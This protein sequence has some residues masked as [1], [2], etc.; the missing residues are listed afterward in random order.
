MCADN[1]KMKIGIKKTRPTNAW[2]VS[3]HVRHILQTFPSIHSSEENNEIE[4]IQG[5]QKKK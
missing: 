4:R 3:A 5:E 2:I 1:L